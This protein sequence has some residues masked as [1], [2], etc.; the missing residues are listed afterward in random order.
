MAI[1]SG[2]DQYGIRAARPSENITVQRVIGTTPTCSGIGV[3]SEMSGGVS[4]ILIRDIHV[5][6]SSSALR[7][8][9]DRGRGGY[10]TNITVTNITMQHVKIPIRFSR[11]ANDHPDKNF[12]SK[13]L[14]RISNVYISN[15]V[16]AGISRAPV[17]EG[18]EGTVYEDICIR[19]VSFR[20]V[21][22][23]ETWTCE[24]VKGEAYDAFPWP[25]D[26]LLRRNGSSSWCNNQH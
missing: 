2:W 22:M 1:K 18:I 17:L 6:N 10:I 14:P 9:S 26:E 12:D 16:G 23:K 20:G 8:K 19:N 3:G 5:Y 4:N 24:F 15:V 7:L 11:G 25:C 13:E 21:K